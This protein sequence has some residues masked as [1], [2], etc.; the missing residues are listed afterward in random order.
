ML[1]LLALT[2]LAS[3]QTDAIKVRLVVD[4]PKQ[5]IAILEKRS[6]GIPIA[7]KDW[8]ILFETEGYRRLKDRE[9]GMK[10]AFT[11]ETFKTFMLSDRALTSLAAWK[12]TLAKWQGMD[13]AAQGQRALDY[14]PKGCKLTASVYFLIKPAKNTFVWEVSTN[15]AIM[16]YLDPEMSFT[17]LEMT[18]AHEFHHI[19]Y[20]SKCP[21]PEYNK[22]F[23]SLSPRHQT[24]LTWLR[25]LGEGFAVLAAAGGPTGVPYADSAADVKEAWSA[26]MGSISADSEAIQKFFTNILDGALTE[27][28]ITQQAIKFYGITGPWYTVGYSIATTIERAEGR[29]KLLECYMDPRLLLPTYNR[30]ATKM[31]KG[32]AKLPIWPEDLSR[33]MMGN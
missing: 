25:A 7:D 33:R 19:G 15:P 32:G 26:G 22:W 9:L 21:S 5:A 3:T 27:E 16:A 30:A 29:A 8:T 2:C 20:G 28:Q 23:E 14:L 17:D 6:Q 11:E 31:N 1:H 18:I 13:L 4:E 24:A 12:A 10:R